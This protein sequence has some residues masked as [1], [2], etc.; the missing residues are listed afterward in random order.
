MRRRSHISRGVGRHQVT[1]RPRYPTA[2]TVRR[3]AH[4]VVGGESP[5]DQLIDRL[6]D[7]VRPKT[8]TGHVDD[9]SN[10]S[11]DTHPISD[12]DIVWGQRLFRGM[13]SNTPRPTTATTGSRD[14]DMDA[15]RDRVANS[16]YFQGAFV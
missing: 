7:K 2:L 10:R 11:R 14:S 6:G 9:G 15:V 5:I 12:N 1:N 13:N 3:C 16:K 8:G 4:L